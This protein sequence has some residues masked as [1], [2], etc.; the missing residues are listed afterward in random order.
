M[1][2]EGKSGKQARNVKSRRVLQELQLQ[3]CASV[4][5]LQ[6]QLF[7]PLCLAR[8]MVRDDDDDH[9]QC[10]TL[11]RIISGGGGGGGQ[12]KRGN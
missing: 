12:A 8:L 7:L 6:Q 10:T 11:Y 5:L 1:S 4:G 3:Q 2:T 9:Q